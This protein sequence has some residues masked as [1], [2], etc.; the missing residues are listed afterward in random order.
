MNP[1]EL[2]RYSQS[3]RPHG[4]RLCLVLFHHF[5]VPS[6][7]LSM[8]EKAS[9]GRSCRWY[10]W[11]RPVTRE[12]AALWIALLARQAAALLL[13]AISR[14]LNCCRVHVDFTDTFSQWNVALQNS[15]AL[16]VHSH[17]PSLTQKPRS[18]QMC[19]EPNG[20]LHRSLCLSSLNTSVQCLCLDV[21]Q[22]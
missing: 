3:H 2:Q 22:C 18:M 12:P 11:E 1:R 15:S 19:T 4:S 20:K 13:T 7:K 21:S 10:F 17:W 5:T 8:G 9:G 14:V 16:K 6:V